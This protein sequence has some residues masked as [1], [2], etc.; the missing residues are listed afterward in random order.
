MVNKPVSK[1]NSN[2]VVVFPHS[3]QS[4]NYFCWTER[5]RRPGWQHGLWGR[6]WFGVPFNRTFILTSPSHR[7]VQCVEVRCRCTILPLSSS[8]HIDCR[9][10]TRQWVPFTTNCPV[11]WN[12][13]AAAVK[14]FPNSK[15]LCQLTFRASAPPPPSSL[16]HQQQKKRELCRVTFKD[17]RLFLL[18][19][20]PGPYGAV[21]LGQSVQTI[22]KVLFKQFLWGLASV[23][24]TCFGTTC[25]RYA[26]V[27]KSAFFAILHRCQPQYLPFAASAYRTSRHND[28]QCQYNCSTEKIR[29]IFHKK[30]K[31][32]VFLKLKS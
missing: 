6:K 19:P 11:E 17:Q 8:P 10:H 3:V 26:C 22:H 23:K 30:E 5:P 9:H 27:L 13:A 14:A 7:V 1:K 4:P 15:E 28:Q 25:P 31:L 2:K 12:S 32:E 16:Q 18:L 24:F 21:I 20:T 29:W